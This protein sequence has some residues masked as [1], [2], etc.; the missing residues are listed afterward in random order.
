MN[1]TKNDK[2]SDFFQISSVQVDLCLETPF[3]PFTIH[4]SY[5]VLIVI[6]QFSSLEIFF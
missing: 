6:L 5:F 3:T 4:Y 2:L 1:V